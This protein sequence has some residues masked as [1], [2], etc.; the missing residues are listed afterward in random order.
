ME[1]EIIKD[2]DRILAIILKN[3]DFA[4]GLHFYTKDSDFVQVSTWNYNAGK[5]TIPHTHKLCERTANRTQEIIFVKSGSMKTKI[6]NDQDEFV[7]GIILRMGDVAVILAG[8]HSYEILENNTQI[9]E[10]KNGPYLGLEKD[11]KE[12]NIKI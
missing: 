1:K 8:G 2:K 11:K 9:L 4:E 10:M 6:Y 7:K 12:I 3:G 5:I